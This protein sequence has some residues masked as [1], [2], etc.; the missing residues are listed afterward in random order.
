VTESDLLSILSGL[1]GDTQW[2]RAVRFLE[3]IWRV[4][5]G[6]TVVDAARAIGSTAGKI[7]GIV[8]A[9]DSAAAALG[10]SFEAIT[11]DSRRG[12]R[13]ALGQMLLGRCAELVFEDR[14]RNEMST[15]EL[16]LTNVADAATDTDYRLLNGQ[17]RYLF[18]INIKFHGSPFRNAKE[19]VGLEPENCF[20]LATYKINSALQKQMEEGKPYFFAIVGV[21]N[22]TADV[23]GRR[24]PPEIIDV[25]ALVLSAEVPLKRKFEDAIIDSA[26]RNTVPAFR[27][28]Y[29]AI[30][31][32][33]WYILSAPRADRLLHDKLFD[34]VLALR[35]RN[36]TRVFRG[37]EVDMHFSLSED[38]IPLSRFFE[39]LREGGV[40]KVSTLIERGDL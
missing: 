22:L 37:A 33:D 30:E 32:A 28:T 7:Q 23:A 17:G 10:V 14:Y 1:F 4:R 2:P 11:D 8:D 9:D 40:V 25:A 26:V 38:L 21:P 18:R 24:F 35:V 19:W 31:T 15:E 16:R 13:K 36:F 29:A 12:A 5:E 20:A 27:E 6:S 3:A 34:R 39:H